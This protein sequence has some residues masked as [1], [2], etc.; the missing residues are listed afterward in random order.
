MMAAAMI[1][2][3]GCIILIASTMVCLVIVC[4]ATPT[5]TAA[6]RLARL[7]GRLRAASARGARDERRGVAL[8]AGPAHAALQIRAPSRLARDQSVE[9]IHKLRQQSLALLTT[10]RQAG[11]ITRLLKQAAQLNACVVGTRI[12]YQKWNVE[13]KALGEQY[14]WSPLVVIDTNATQSLVANVSDRLEADEVVHLV[15]HNPIRWLLLLSDFSLVLWFGSVLV[16][17]LI[18]VLV[19]FFR[20]S[21]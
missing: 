8:A 3:R 16:L 1:A 2:S 6:A 14:Q 4:V 12:P 11:N 13:T 15:G 20:L 7:H 18:L 21:K 19:L 9:L 10:R 5:A 17:V